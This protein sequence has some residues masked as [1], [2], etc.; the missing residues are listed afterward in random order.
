MTGQERKDIL[1]E[2]FGDR[3]INMLAFSRFGGIV[4]AMLT[5][6]CDMDICEAHK[7]VVKSFKC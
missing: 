2:V 1:D 5:L 7:R 4:E 3:W 6:F